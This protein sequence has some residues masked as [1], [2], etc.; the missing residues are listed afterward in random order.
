M[1]Y[2]VTV[3]IDSSRSATI[4]A[5]SPEQAADKA[6]DELGYPS[7][8]HQCANEL[9]VGD[10]IGALVYDAAAERQLL[11]TTYSGERIAALE[12]EGDT[13]RA[14][15]SFLLHADEPMSFLRAW[16]EGNFD[17]CR[18]E[19]PEAP[20]SLYPAGESPSA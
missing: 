20:E 18:R 10:A 4:E 12:K 2:A 1:K 6:M 11:D 8:C 15:V 14:L 3:C 16:N 7:I 9:E 17:A 13:F 5:D 19:W